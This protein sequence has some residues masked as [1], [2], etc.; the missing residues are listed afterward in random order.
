M[1]NNI[2]NDA[3]KLRVRGKGSG[4]KEGTE[5]QGKIY[6]FENIILFLIFFFFFPLIFCSFKYL[7]LYPFI[8][9]VSPSI[10]TI[11]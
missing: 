9:K 4:F 5:K 2:S 10:R 1:E 7:A 6:N 11:Y 8:F 3:I